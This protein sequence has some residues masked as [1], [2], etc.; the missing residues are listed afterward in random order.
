MTIAKRIK[1]RRE[2]LGLSQEALARK[3][4]WRQSRISGYEIGTKVPPLKTIK[5]LEEALGL[6]PGWLTVE[7]YPES[8]QNIRDSDNN[9]KQSLTDNSIDNNV[10][11]VRIATPLIT[12][13]WKPLLTIQEASDWRN[14]MEEAIR[15]PSREKIE[16]TLPSQQYPHCFLVNIDNDANYPIFNVGDM[17]V[18]DPDVKVVPGCFVVAKML[19]TSQNVFA[20]YAV[21]GE[22]TVLK[23]LNE[24]YPTTT[25]AP[26]LIEVIGV[27]VYTLK[28]LYHQVPQ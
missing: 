2:A 23:F 25:I 1:L 5:V 19:T 18:I 7:N 4:G 6:P 24:H 20:Q 15:D 12:H 11:I 27:A 21:K 10:G 8:V 14:K 3:C 16:L 26:E 13:T 22:E 9:F 28:K 17:V